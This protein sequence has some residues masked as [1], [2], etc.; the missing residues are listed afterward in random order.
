MTLRGTGN[1]WADNEIL[2]A[3]DLNNTIQP[4]QIRPNIPLGRIYLASVGGSPNTYPQTLGSFV[5]PSGTFL[6][7]KDCLAV[8]GSFQH[9]KSLGNSAKLIFMMSGANYGFIEMVSNGVTSA[10]GAVPSIYV[11]DS[12][13]MPLPEQNTNFAYLLN[14]APASAGFSYTAIGSAADSTW[15]NKDVVLLVLGSAVT[16]SFTFSQFNAECLRST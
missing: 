10:A 2:Y 1:A 15:S 12:K 6:G 7:S 16:G 9:G 13:I 5:F 3:A 4:L 14:Y 11:W 8:Y